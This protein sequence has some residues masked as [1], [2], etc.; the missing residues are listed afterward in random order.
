MK[1]MNKRI[2]I[3]GVIAA[4][5]LSTA[6]FAGGYRKKIEVMFNS[7]NIKVNGN[8]VKANN[9]VY[10]GTTYVPIRAVSEMLEKEVKWDKKTRTAS[11]NDI[12]K[13]IISE[14]DAMDLVGNVGKNKYDRFSLMPSG[15]EN[16]NNKMFYVIRLFE[17]HPTHIATLG[18]YYVDSETGDVY[19]WDLIEDE[20]I[21]VD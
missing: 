21:L 18:W 14:E 17:D 4:L 2:L 11:I 1:N 5:L 12:D 16:V 8:P 10:N 7:V 19:E 20:L 6:A 15:T 9:I 3:F 13:N